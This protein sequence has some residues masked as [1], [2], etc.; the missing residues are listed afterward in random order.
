[1]I[2]RMDG[3]SIQIEAPGGKRGY[4]IVSVEYIVAWHGAARRQARIRTM[5][6]AV[7]PPARA[8][9]GGSRV[10]EAGGPGR[11]FRC[12]VRRRREAEGSL[13]RAAAAEPATRLSGRGADPRAGRGRCPDF[14][15][16]ARRS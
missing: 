7:A 2:G 8:G 14:R 15:M 9:G 16:A 4:E 11:S 1:M 12:G 5:A 10:R 13:R 6:A 3:D